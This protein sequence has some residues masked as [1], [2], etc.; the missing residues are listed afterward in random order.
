MKTY[1]LA[2]SFS[3]FVFAGSASFAGPTS[4]TFFASSAFLAGPEVVSP[5]TSTGP[6]AASRSRTPRYYVM[7]KH[8]KLIE[9]SHGKQNP[10]KKDITLTNETT[11]HPNGAIDAGSGQGQLLK[12]GQY[13]TMD[14]KIRNLKDMP[15]PVTGH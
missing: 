11:I 14:G 8:G 9:V 3:L 4:S 13:I 12:E 5:G 6:T 15:H 7:M 2:F 10:V 1:A